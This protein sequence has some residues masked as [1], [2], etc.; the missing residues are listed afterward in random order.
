MTRHWRHEPLDPSRAQPGDKFYCGHLASFFDP[1]Y[2][3]RYLALIEGRMVVFR[4]Y[5]RSK[6]WWHYRIEE[7]EHLN[8]LREIDRERRYGKPRVRTAGE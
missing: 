7:L 5:G 3:A 8:A 1:P 4:F 2:T 6:Q